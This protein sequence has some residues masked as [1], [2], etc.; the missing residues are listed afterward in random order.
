LESVTTDE[1]AEGFQV[2]DKNPMLGVESRAALLR[3]L[4]KSLLVHSDIFG[5]EGRPGNL[6]GKKS[7]LYAKSLVQRN[8]RLHDENCQ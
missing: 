1:L 3:S 5:A 4:G 7:S 6:V 8:H 2:S